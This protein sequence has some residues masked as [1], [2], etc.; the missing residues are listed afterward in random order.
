MRFLDKLLKRSSEETQ[1]KIP[2]DMVVEMREFFLGSYAGRGAFSYLHQ[3]FGWGKSVETEQDKANH[4]MIVHFRNLCGL[5]D[6]AMAEPMSRA[7]LNAAKE[8][9]STEETLLDLYKVGINEN[10][11][12][13]ARQTKQRDHITMDFPGRKNVKDIL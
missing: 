9:K 10:S 12:S 1:Q 7:E 13:N 6:P 2:L 8:K 3:E 5:N 4:N 11:Y